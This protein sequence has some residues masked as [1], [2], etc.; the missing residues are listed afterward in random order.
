MLALGASDLASPTDD[1]D[2]TM[3]SIAHRL[4]SIASLKKAVAAGITSWEQGNAMLATCFTLLFQS[5]LLN[6][7][8]AEYLSF[9]RGVVAIAMQ[10][11]QK[12]MKFVF[13]KL[14]GDEYLQSMEPAL[15]AAPLINNG[16]VSRACRSLEKMAPLCE[17]KA[18]IGIYGILLSIARNLITS[19]RECKFETC[20]SDDHMLR[21][22]A[23]IS[24]RRVYGMFMM[25]SQDEFREFTDPSNEV[26]QLLQAHFVALQLIMTPITRAEFGQRTTGNTNNTDGR[27]GRWLET[28]H[29]TIPP[30]LLQYYEWTLWVETATDAGAIGK[31]WR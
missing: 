1:Q 11:S 5:V 15:A 8:L 3:I 21:C 26:C 19:S 10:M 4:N 24:L 12:K 23:Y 22:T 30:H 6:D 2:L 7:G 9:F 14:F 18:A 25:M 13:T 29:K 16:I 28:L 27:T 17:T 31:G 20:P